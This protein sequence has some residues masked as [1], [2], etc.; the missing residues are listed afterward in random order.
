MKNINAA[1]VWMSEV[2]LDK[3][4][5]SKRCVKIKQITKRQKELIQLEIYATE[6]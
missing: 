2:M 3:F 5:G 4:K 6:K 1:V